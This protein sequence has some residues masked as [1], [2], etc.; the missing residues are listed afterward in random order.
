M[1]KLAEN[2]EA[3]NLLS[4]GFKG[5]SGSIGG[6]L[7]ISAFLQMKAK[8]IKVLDQDLDLEE[9]EPIELSLKRHIILSVVL[10]VRAKNL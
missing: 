2:L 1:N 3:Q 6:N 7:F 5:V 4:D 9:I 8:S 10:Q